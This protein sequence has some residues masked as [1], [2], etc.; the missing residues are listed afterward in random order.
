M[1]TGVVFAALALA[2][3]SA[4]LAHHHGRHHARHHAHHAT[5]R[6]FGA[7]TT[8]TTAAP[9]TGS[10]S[11]PTPTSP[12]TEPAGK[13]VSFN[14]GVLVIALTGGGEVSGK[15]TEA[16][17]LECEGTEGSDDDS[18][19]GSGDH[20]WTSGHGDDMSTGGPG[21]GSG[22]DEG[23]DDQGDDDQGGTPCTTSALV[24]GAVVRW[25]ALGIGPGGA[26]WLKVAL[27]A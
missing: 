17:H 16:T 4:A 8:T 6:V 22:G 5:V 11:T 3:P 26:V 15:V 23:D 20:S 21:S 9:T 1:L 10:P 25:A 13:V 27:A 7:H 12:T 2:L 19:S 18:G 14:E 24:P